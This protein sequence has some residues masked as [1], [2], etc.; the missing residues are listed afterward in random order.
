MEFLPPIQPLLLKAQWIESDLSYDG[1]NPARVPFYA[2]NTR[3]LDRPYTIR[4]G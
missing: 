4:K 3:T 2:M 1:L